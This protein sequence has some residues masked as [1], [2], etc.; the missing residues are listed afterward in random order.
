ML[1][2]KVG[3]DYKSCDKECLVNQGEEYNVPINTAVGPAKVAVRIANY[4][5]KN[6]TDKYFDEG[7]GHQSDGVSIQFQITFNEDV[8]GDDVIW[9]NDFDKPIRDMLP[10]GTSIGLKIL[11]WIDPTVD[12]DVYADEP[13]LY[14]KALGSIPS[15]QEGSDWGYIPRGQKLVDL[16][17]SQ[18]E[19]R[20]QFTFK[21]GHTY[22]FDFYTPYLSLG[23]DL[24]VKLPGFELNV[25]KYCRSQ[26]L[27]YVLK[28]KDKPLVLV[29]FSPA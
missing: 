7:N 18:P 24:A 19:N 26:P 16:D 20:K 2:V 21:K 17:F 1:L 25:E 5:G 15:I 14:G 4:N 22:Q 3:S 23:S 13:Y 9:G 28:L 27:R 29:A 10:Y 8:N 6:Q 11:K 12:G